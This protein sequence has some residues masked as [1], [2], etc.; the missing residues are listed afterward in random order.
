MTFKK[1]LNI[2]MKIESQLKLPLT[3][4]MHFKI[5]NSIHLNKNL[6]YYMQQ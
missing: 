3:S 1:S 6:K 4:S 5:Y 2:F